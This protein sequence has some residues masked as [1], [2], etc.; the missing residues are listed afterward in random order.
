MTWRGEDAVAYTPNDDAR[1]SRLREV[2]RQSWDRIAR[3]L[4]RGNSG[5][6]VRMRYGKVVAAR[7][8]AAVAPVTKPRPC[9]RC[10]AV[11]SSIGPGNRL[12]ESCHGAVAAASPYEP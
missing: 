10:R 11:F 2:E 5:A 9:L 4:G 1:I 3:A 7:A 6:A 8:A 12:C